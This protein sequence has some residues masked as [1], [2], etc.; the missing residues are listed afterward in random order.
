[1]RLDNSRKFTLALNPAD[2]CTRNQT[3]FTLI[4]QKWLYGPETIRQKILDQKDIN[5][6][7]RFEESLETNT[8]L[9]ADTS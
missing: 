1:M 6:R 2:L 7:N 3:D 8:S 9:M 5:I 4:Q